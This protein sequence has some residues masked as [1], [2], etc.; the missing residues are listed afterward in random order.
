M[1]GG[2]KAGLGVRYVMARARGWENGKGNGTARP[3]LRR[4]GERN[5]T[6]DMGGV[7]RD[8]GEER[9][10]GWR[11]WAIVNATV[12]VVVAMVV[13]LARRG[14]APPLHGSGLPAGRRSVP[15]DRC[16]IVPNKP[17]GA[18]LTTGD[19]LVEVL[20]ETGQGRHTT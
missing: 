3:V 10:G 17:A 15:V 5:G 6:G 13:R 9:G 16:R 4:E 8:M 14:R 11:I 2:W 20:L 19:W 12:A 18:F 7:R 1:E